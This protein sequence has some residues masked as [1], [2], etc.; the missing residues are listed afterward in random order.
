MTESSTKATPR[1]SLALNAFTDLEAVE[2]ERDTLLAE[3]DRLKAEVEQLKQTLHH[4]IG[5]KSRGGTAG[6]HHNAMLRLDKIARLAA[7]ALKE[8][9]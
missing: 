8:G 2:H 6:V 1:D 4:I 7:A 3:R 9:E 5:I